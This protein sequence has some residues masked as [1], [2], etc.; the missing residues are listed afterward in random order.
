MSC[1]TNPHHYIIRM[2]TYIDMY[3]TLNTLCIH[4]YVLHIC[5]STFWIGS[6]L[7]VIRHPFDLLEGQGQPVT[8]PSRSE[9]NSH[10]RIVG[11]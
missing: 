3:I 11:T 8:V 7:V 9:A 1:T 2:Y 10:R 6:G 4:R 5:M